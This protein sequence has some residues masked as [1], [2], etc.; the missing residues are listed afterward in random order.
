MKR[1]R[2]MVM[3]STFTLGRTEKNFERW[4]ELGEKRRGRE[5]RKKKRKLPREIWRVGT[6]GLPFVTP[7]KG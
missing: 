6:E 4:S 2:E 5:L 7:R 3:E 1:E